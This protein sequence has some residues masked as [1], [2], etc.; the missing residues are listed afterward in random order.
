[1]PQ[2]GNYL[3]GIARHAVGNV[4]GNIGG[5]VPTTL[6]TATTV[7]AARDHVEAWGNAN[8]AT[9]ANLATANGMIAAIQGNIGTAGAGLTNLGDTR[10]GSTN[11]GVASVQTQLGTAG[12]GLTNLGDARIASMNDSIANVETQ[13]GTAGGGLTALGDARLDDIGDIT[14]VA[15]NTTAATILEAL[16]SATPYGAVDDVAPGAGSFV[17]DLTAAADDYYAGAYLLF[18]SGALLGQSRRIV[19]STAGTMV[20]ESPF[21]AAPA[22]ADDFLILGRSET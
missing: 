4:T 3:R 5:V 13:V 22:N 14:K 6:A 11:T 17:T 21:T 18:Y 9:A 1:V 7:T 8:W 12:A 10:I 16:F 15:G 19:S 20:L 2:V